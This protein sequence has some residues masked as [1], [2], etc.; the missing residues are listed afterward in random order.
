MDEKYQ[1][2]ILLLLLRSTHWTL[3]VR[4]HCRYKV[5]LCRSMCRLPY[6]LHHLQPTLHGT[7]ATLSSRRI[8]QE[9]WRHNDATWRS[10]E[11]LLL[12]TRSWKMNTLL[13]RHRSQ[14]PRQS[15][16]RSGQNNTVDMTQNLQKT[17]SIKFCNHMAIIQKI[18]NQHNDTNLE[19]EQI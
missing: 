18:F 16:A 2:S 12:W 6:L 13:L 7:R 9:F 10:G 8:Y 15:W 5:H 3:E 17:Q 4:I 11:L 1:P 19:L 14:S